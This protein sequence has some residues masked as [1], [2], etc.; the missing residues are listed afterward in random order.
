MIVVAQHLGVELVAETEHKIKF[1][2]AVF[3]WLVIWPL[4]RV[5]LEVIIQVRF[6]YT[7]LIERVLN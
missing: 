3:A 1:D 7:L 5:N 4:P 6:E 2:N